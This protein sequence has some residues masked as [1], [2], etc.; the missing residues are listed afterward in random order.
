VVGEDLSLGSFV[1]ILLEGEE[2]W[3]AVSTF[4]ENVIPTFE[5]LQIVLTTLQDHISSQGAIQ[6]NGRRG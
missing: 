6:R 4:C 2:K 5:T 1:K 3:E